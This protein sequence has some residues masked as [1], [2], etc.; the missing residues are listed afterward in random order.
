MSLT[1]KSEGTSNP[2]SNVP[3]SCMY[4]RTIF[5]AAEIK[6]G[7]MYRIKKPCLYFGI[8]IPSSHMSV[9]Y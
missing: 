7:D 2:A 5:K 4:N 8:Y 6:V 1:L 9:M 3:Q